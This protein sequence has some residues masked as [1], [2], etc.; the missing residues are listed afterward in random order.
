[1][2]DAS[3]RYVWEVKGKANDQTF[4]IYYNAETGDEEKVLQV[5]ESPD[6][7]YTM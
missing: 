2:S 7:T 3:E 1:M 4:L 5:I 6:G